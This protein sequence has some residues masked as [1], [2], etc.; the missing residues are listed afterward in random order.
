MSGRLFICLFSILFV[1]GIASA[2]GWSLVWQDDFDGTALNDGSWTVESWPPLQYNQELQRYVPGHDKPNTNV[3]VENH[4]LII[5][6]KL[7]GSDDITSGRIDTRGKRDWLYGRFEARAILP[8]GLGTWPAIW[9]MPTDDAYGGWPKSG[10]ID[11]ME[12]VGYEPDRIYG[13]I[14]CYAYNHTIGT[15][16]NGNITVQDVAHQYHVYAMEWFPDS[17]SFF[18]DTIKY[19]TFDNQHM[20]WQ[21]WPFDKR[22]HWILNIAIGGEWGGTHGVDMGMFPV[23]MTVDYVKVYQWDPNL[24]VRNGSRAAA[25]PA[26]PLTLRSCRVAGHALTIIYDCTLPL[27]AGGGIYDMKG[28]RVMLLSALSADAGRHAW[29]VPLQGRPLSAGLYIVNLRAGTAGLSRAVCI[30]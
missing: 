7:S 8:E 28:S 9:M 15:E 27:A 24:A 2:Q 26:A 19:F 18:V 3:R 10:E 11:I 4:N 5:E 16:K 20:D 6:S 17:I 30:P 25:R 29:T 13:T 21:T 12:N 22:F 1:R 14:H 23:R